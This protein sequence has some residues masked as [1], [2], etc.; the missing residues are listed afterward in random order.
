MTDYYRVML[1]RGSEH[2]EECF[3]GGFIGTDF[4]LHQDLSRHLP[5]EWRTFNK[6]FIPVYQAKWPDKSKIAAGLACGAIWTVSKGMQI[7][8]LLLCP[9]GGG[10]YQIGEVAGD[11]YYAEGATLPHRRPVKWWN[12]HVSRESMTEALQ[13]S[14]GVPGTVSTITKHAEEIEALIA[15]VVPPKIVTTDETIED[16]EKFV[17]EKHLEDFLVHNWSCTELGAEYS[18]FQDDGE[19]V[20]QQ[21]QTDTGPIDILAI[22]KD[23]ATLLVVELKKGRASDAVVGQLLRYMNFVAEELAAPGAAGKRDHHRPGR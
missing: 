6:Q 11:Y 21:Y 20:G 14:T 1:G 18:I 17:I 5:D 23:E 4:G 2:A 8:D 19:T 3:A 10:N 12:Q 15:G 7:S 9:D 16:P 22:S 13:N